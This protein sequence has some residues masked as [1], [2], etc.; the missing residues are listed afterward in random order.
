MWMS[1]SLERSSPKPSHSSVRENALELQELF[2]ECVDKV[3]TEG[4]RMGQDVRYVIQDSVFNWDSD[5]AEAN[6][7]NHDGVSFEEACEVFFDPWYQMEEDTR[8]AGEQRWIFVGYSRANR[9]LYVVAVE[10]GEESWRIVSAR[11]LE[12]EERRR[13]EK[14]DD[15]Y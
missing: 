13:Y 10:Q 2:R 4:F 15:P 8:S 7:R 5:K 11:K 1:Y 9:P 14:E 3:L 12:P 6:V